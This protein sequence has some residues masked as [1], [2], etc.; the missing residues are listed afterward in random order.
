MNMR[1][2]FVHLG[3]TS[4]LLLALAGC[5]GGGD[6]TSV[7]ATPANAKSATGLFSWVLPVAAGSGQPDLVRAADGTLLLSWMDSQPGRRTRLQIADFG[8]DN[9]WGPPRTVAIGSSFVSNWADTPHVVATPNN[10][11]WIQWLQ[12]SGG[13]DGYN[14]ILSN[15]RDGGTTWAAPVSPHD[16]GSAGEHGFASLW[17]V[18]N[19]RLGIAWLD[20]GAN[21][22][23]AGKPGTPKTDA[24][25]AG[26]EHTGRTRLRSAVFDT[27]LHRVSEAEV[28]A[29]VCD[30]C[31]TDA[32]VTSKGTVLVYRGRTADEIRDIQIARFDGNAWSKGKPVAVDNW[33]MPACPVNGPSVAA[34][35][36]HVLVGWYTA[37]GDAPAVKLARST[38]AG[39]SFSA[40][41]QLDQGD[42]V[43][44]RIKVALDKQSAWAL[45]LREEGAGQTLWLARFSPD[46][47]K[48]LERVQVAKLQGRGRGTGFPQLA[49]R[50]GKAYI[51]WTDIVGGQSGLHGASYV[52]GK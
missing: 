46:L 35:G 49:L 20:G 14:T 27:G 44:G 31:Q 19:D 28:D 40:P 8:T 50:D 5:S 12:K 7:G 25:A 45:W 41:V 10:W 33:K 38:D 37:P 47:S 6:D 24:H 21:A 2:P 3:V 34:D 42:A 30:C 48:E 29:S 15:S 52:P 18:G 51:V 23:P 17:A 9:A 39:D 26:G 43:Q 32:A 36:V 16:G 1:I 13:S 22:A 11:L 4:A